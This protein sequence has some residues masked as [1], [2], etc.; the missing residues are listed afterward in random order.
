[1]TVGFKDSFDRDA[2]RALGSCPTFLHND[3]VA[4]ALT[5]YGGLRLQNPSGS[6]ERSKG[7]KVNEA[8]V[9]E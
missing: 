6:D 4:A 7:C 1:M 3:R 2:D 8:A 9:D 5:H